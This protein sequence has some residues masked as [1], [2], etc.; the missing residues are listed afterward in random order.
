ML[1]EVVCHAF[2]AICLAG[3]L[4]ST[5]R[6][7]IA[8]DDGGIPT[9]MRLNSWTVEPAMTAT[10]NEDSQQITCTRCGQ[11]VKGRSAMEW[12]RYHQCPIKAVPQIMPD[13]GIV[14][15][16]G[17]DPWLSAIEIDWKY[18]CEH[19]EWVLRKM[20]ESCADLNTAGVTISA[21]TVTYNV[22]AEIK[23]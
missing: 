1:L 15:R 8:Q 23:Q 9:E 16:N 7:V 13:P 2:A 10:I 3:F 17:P 21:G 11:H 22:T 4:I 6:E 12:G 19:R 20:D 14:F 18:L 5:A